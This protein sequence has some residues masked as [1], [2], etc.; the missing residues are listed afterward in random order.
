MRYGGDHHALLLADKKV[1][2]ER[3]KAP[4]RI[5]HFREENDINQITWQVQSLEEVWEATQY[6]KDLE[7]E[8]RTEGRGAA[9]M[10]YHLYMWDPDEQIDELYYGIEQVGWDGKARPKDMYHSMTEATMQPQINEFDEIQQDVA[11]GHDMFAGYR[12][13]DPLPAKYDVNKILLTRPFK[14]VKIGPVKLFCDDVQVAKEYY[15]QVFGFRLTE[16]ASWQREKAYFLRVDNEHHSLGLFPKSWRS[17]LGLSEKTSSMSLGL[18]LANY[19]Q[20]KDAVGF[21]RDNGVRVETD[22]V[23]PSLHPG[24]DYAAYAFDPDGHCIELYYYMEQL[25]WDGQVRPQALRRKVDPNNWPEALE[26]L[27][28]TYDGEPFLGPWG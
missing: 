15:E 10:N 20:L 7:I 11:A 3:N 24:I 5:K 28:D 21:L 8:V 12:Y 18:Q 2:D 27:S 16:E 19:Q 22:I 1:A 6:F 14:V 23:P 9:G 17:K 26:P 4:E 13:E 25:G